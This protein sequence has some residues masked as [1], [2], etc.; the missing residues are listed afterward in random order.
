MNLGFGVV[1]TNLLGL[2]IMI[3]VGFASVKTKIVPPST[4]ATLS[5]ILLKITLPC[6]I[7]ISLATKEYDP[8]FSRFDFEGVAQYE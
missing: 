6:T 7:F 4:S 1:F 2:F 5:A 8:G 3:G